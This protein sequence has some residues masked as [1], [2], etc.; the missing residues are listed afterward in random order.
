MSEGESWTV[1]PTGQAQI[2]TRGVS[3][4]PLQAPTTIATAT[5][6]G[7]YTESG[8]LTIFAMTGSATYT[9]SELSALVSGAGIGAPTGYDQADQ[10]EQ[11]FNDTG[12]A[13]RGGVDF[14]AGTYIIGRPITIRHSRKD[15]KWTGVAGGSIGISYGLRMTG[16]SPGETVLKYTG[17]TALTDADGNLRP[18]ILITPPNNQSSPYNANRD[19]MSLVEG[20]QL[21]SAPSG[22]RSPVGSP[23]GS[24]IEFRPESAAIRVANSPCSHTQELRRLIIDGF[25][26]GLSLYD[27][28]L[29]KIDRVWWQDFTEAL[30][31]GYNS[32]FIELDQCM[33]GM[34]GY[35]VGTGTD[36][37][38]HRLNSVA[39][40]TGW[41]PTPSGGGGY[42]APGGA[43]CVLL[44]EVWCR[45]IDQFMVIGA[46]EQGIK[47]DN[48][49][50][51]G[52]S[53][54]ISAPSTTG[55]LMLDLDSCHFSNPASQNL[56]WN[57]SRV[58]TMFAGSG[59]GAKM[60]IA[61]TDSVVTLRHCT[62]DTANSPPGGYI[63]LRAGGDKH[64][65]VMEA[66]DLTA[67]ARGHIVFD[68]GSSLFKTRTIPNRA[69]GSYTFGGHI[70]IGRIGGQEITPDGKA[71]SAYTALT[72]GTTTIDHLTADAYSYT[73][74]TSGTVTFTT[75]SGNYPPDGSRI[76]LRLKSP[77]SGSCTIA[78]SGYFAPDTITQ[79]GASLNAYS[80]F[81]FECVNSR[82]IQVS[83]PNKWVS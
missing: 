31:L 74:P 69:N 14:G 51:E 40:K 48:V 70:G 15:A 10:I 44:R 27:A 81:E 16:I 82:L 12:G 55:R 45:D 53:Q 71:T 37:A 25:A 80:Y 62:S 76:K 47:W 46:N 52:V 22:V 2:S 30:R 33:F 9:G 41:A 20:F 17:S 54:F 34:E 73:L 65:I 61:C 26:Y 28:T 63:R 19:Y 59:Y 50:L 68:D 3:G 58:S 66:N 39:I 67:G 18:A 29:F 32:D 42:L 4:G 21:I 57:D 83:A 56:A 64:R 8:T 72:A 79:H 5:T 24:G 7:P 38:G 60:D 36:G 13:A 11:Y 43:N 6:F 1:T 49:Y 77:A 78:F 35:G 75:A 23:A